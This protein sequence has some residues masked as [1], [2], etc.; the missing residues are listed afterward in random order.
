MR[1]YSPKI[2]TCG[3]RQ[4]RCIRDEEAATYRSCAFVGNFAALALGTHSGEIRLHD[5]LSG[6]LIDTL[7]AHEAP[8]Y[9]L[10]V[11]AAIPHAV[12]LSKLLYPSTQSLSS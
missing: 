8:V 7:D 5:T 9:Q 1:R 3:C 6:D 12:S 2:L 11:S 4:V 10:R